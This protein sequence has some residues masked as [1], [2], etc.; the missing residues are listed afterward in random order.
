M[1]DPSHWLARWWRRTRALTQHDRTA[2]AVGRRHR[3][4]DGGVHLGHASATTCAPPAPSLLA[5]ALGVVPLDEAFSGFSDD[6]VIIVG[7]A[8]L[9]SA[10]VAR[11]G[12]MEAALQR[13]A[14]NV[15]RVQDA[16]AAARGGRDRA[17]G[18]REEHRRAGDH[19]PDRV[20]V[21]QAIGCLGL[22]LPDADGVRLAA[23]RADDADRHLAEHRG[24][25]G[26]RGADRPELHDV[27][28]HASGRERSRPSG[29]VFLTLFYRLAAGAQPRDR[30]ASTRRSTS[31]T[32]SSR[33]R[34]SRPPRCL[35]SRSRTF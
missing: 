15:R 10:G 23:R 16:A 9:V 24:L 19:D 8:L 17:L 12:I 6:I 21:R 18:L 28:L 33:P 5:L 27:R 31:A 35:A 29:V 13:L 1:A 14:P 3:A 22:G 25:A 2:T 34:C 4:D 11:S 20:P 26:A 30:R 32:T 7:S